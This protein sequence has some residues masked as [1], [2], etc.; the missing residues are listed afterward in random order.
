L[1]RCFE[2][3]LFEITNLGQGNIP[4]TFSV[5]QPLFELRIDHDRSTTLGRTPFTGAA[6][7]L[8]K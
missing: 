2:P 8:F 7:T 1:E 3:Y 6:T 5:A 4:T